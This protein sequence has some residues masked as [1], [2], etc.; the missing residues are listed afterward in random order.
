MV[1]FAVSDEPPGGD[2][3]LFADIIGA[4]EGFDTVSAALSESGFIGERSRLS[5]EMRKRSSAVGSELLFKGYL[6]NPAPVDFA[7]KS[8][9]REVSGF[10]P[11]TA[12]G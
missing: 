7:E 10:R 12:K 3:A 6:F 11:K 8:K 2:T 1:L 9:G 4:G 5:D